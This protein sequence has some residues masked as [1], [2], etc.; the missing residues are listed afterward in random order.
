MTDYA[1][2]DNQAY[3]RYGKFEK[4]IVQ[5]HGCSYCGRE[6]PRNMHT[7]LVSRTRFDMPHL[8]INHWED[9]GVGGWIILK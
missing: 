2:P 5:E 7:A 3:G 1:A 9:Q 4:N 6:K 8:N